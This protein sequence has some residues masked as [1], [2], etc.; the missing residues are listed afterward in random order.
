MKNPSSTT[1]SITLTMSYGRFGLS[2]TRVSRSGFNLV[3]SSL[4]FSL[5]GSAILWSG[6]KDRISLAIIQASS[7][8]SA[9]KHAIPERLACKL[10]PPSSTASIS[11]LITS[12]VSS[13]DERNNWPCSCPRIVKSARLAPNADT[14]TTGPNTSEIIGILP[15]H[16]TNLSNNSP[17]PPRDEI[18]SWAAAATTLEGLEW[19]EPK[20]EVLPKRKGPAVFGFST[21]AQIRDNH[22]L[23]IEENPAMTYAA[24]SFGETI[25]RLYLNPVSGHILRR[26][27]RRSVRIVQGFDESRQLQPR[28]LIHLISCAP[29][30]ISMWVKSKEIEK[31]GNFSESMKFNKLLTIEE[32]NEVEIP[33]D[34]ENENMRIKALCVLEEWMDEKTLREIEAEF[35]SQPGDVRT[36]VELADWLLFSARRM[37]TSDTE[38]MEEAAEATSIVSEYISETQRRIRYGCKADI[39]ALVGIR[40]VGRVRAREMKMI[41]IETIYDVS[42]MGPRDRSK[43]EGL[44]GWSPKL[45]ENVITNAQQIISRKR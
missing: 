10:A 44:R 21:A 30:F 39:L 16:W 12:G 33:T 2:G 40:N 42:E 1:S 20:N 6:K 41:G 17:V 25:S 8:S 37:L 26:G 28:S 43:L 13:G 14:P 34:L 9:I 38:L 23:E 5:G 11:P 18:P 15:L 27:L 19:S 22:P 29:D 35:D 32:L 36:R 4:L 3:G 24:T 45:V 31:I 7:S